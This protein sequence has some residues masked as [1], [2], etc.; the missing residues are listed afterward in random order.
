MF[1]CVRELREEVVSISNA[2]NKAVEKKVTLVA[3]ELEIKKKKIILFSSA[4]RKM[5]L[6]PTRIQLMEC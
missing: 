3:E 2:A 4:L 6:Y 5:E 1:S